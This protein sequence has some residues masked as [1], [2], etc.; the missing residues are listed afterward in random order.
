[1]EDL[2]ESIHVAA[3]KEEV[4]EEQQVVEEEEIKEEAKIEREPTPKKV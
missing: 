4:E 3:R 2:I 1:V